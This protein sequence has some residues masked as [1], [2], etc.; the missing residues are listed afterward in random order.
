[1]IIA[2][3]EGAGFVWMQ[4]RLLP[5]T[6]LRGGIGCAALV[7]V[8]HN[9]WN[10]DRK[11]SF[12]WRVGPTGTI[13]AD[14]QL[15]PVT[16]ERVPIL[17]GLEFREIGLLGFSGAALSHLE[18]RRRYLARTWWQVPRSVSGE[19]TYR[20]ATFQENKGYLG[21]MRFQPLTRKYPLR[22]WQPGQIVL[23]ELEFWVYSKPIPG[24]AEIRIEVVGGDLIEDATYTTDFTL[25]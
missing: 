4:L 1:M 25:H 7:L 8:I 10:H 23:D 14:C 19:A 5:Q 16:P 11:I 20:V 18:P 6:W 15:D 24:P 22:Y 2:A 21:A 12:P 13:P 3:C 17:A 9:P